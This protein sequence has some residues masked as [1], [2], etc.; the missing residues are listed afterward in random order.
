MP[1]SAAWTAK[2]SL[3]SAMRTLQSI[4]LLTFMAAYDTRDAIA[5]SKAAPAREE[6][7]SDDQVR[8]AFAKDGL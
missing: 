5:T 8:R 4:A 7:A 1:T 2:G 3:L 6:F